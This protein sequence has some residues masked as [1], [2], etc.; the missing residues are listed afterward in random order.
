MHRPNCAW[1][2]FSGA[3]MG[4]AM[5]A[6][7]IPGSVFWPYFAGAVVLAAGL[8]IVIKADLP[9]ERGWEKVIPFGRLFYAMPMAV[10][11]AEHFTAARFIVR[12]VPAWMPVPR[13][14]VFLVG[15]ALLAAA[16][17]LAVKKYAAL[18]ALLMGIMLL[19]FVVMIHI[20]NVVAQPGDRFLWAIAC[21]DLAFSGGAFAYAGAYGEAWLC[22]GRQWLITVGRFIIAATALFFGVEHFL[23]PGFVPGVPLNKVM[24]AWIPVRLFW[25]YLTGVVLVAAGTSL[26]IRKRV[27]LAATCLGVTI[28]LIVLFVYLPTL[29]VHPSDIG[30]ELNFVVDTLVFSGAAL[31]L[32]DAA[33]REGQPHDVRERESTKPVA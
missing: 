24:A 30:N 25:G 20:P 13:F 7:G 15:L 9:L 31:L 12:I 19:L 11:G 3:S 27:R 2:R 23:H 26:L 32:A 10:F 17:S 21:R 5:V 33:P 16:L 22:R 1:Q 18:A 4:L 29:I 8:P 6:L 28:F 14:W